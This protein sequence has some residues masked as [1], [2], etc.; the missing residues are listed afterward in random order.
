VSEPD[1]KL[2]AMNRELAEM[3][4]SMAI[5]RRSLEEMAQMKQST[6]IVLPDQ[7]RPWFS[8]LR[9]RWARGEL[10]KVERWFVKRILRWPARDCR[11]CRVRLAKLRC[12]TPIHIG[13][14]NGC[15]RYICHHCAWTATDNTHY[16]TNCMIID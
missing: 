13:L 10:L 9:W 12:D 15:A 6:G 1:P 4:R 8:A 14:H 3:R 16:C 11:D 2:V 5:V 7:R